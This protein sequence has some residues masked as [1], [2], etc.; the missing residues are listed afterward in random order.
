[1]ENILKYQNPSSPLLIQ[2]INKSGANFVKRLLDPNRKSIPDWETKGSKIATHKLGWAEDDHG[3]YVFPEVQEIDGQLID[4]SRPPYAPGIAD[5]IAHKNNNIVRMSP[6]EADWFTRNYKQYYPSFKKGGSIHI[7]KKNRGKFT[8]SAKRAGMGVQEFARHVLANKDKHSSTLVKRAN[9]ARNSKKFK[10]ENG[11]ILKAQEGTGNLLTPHPLSP[12]GIALN[13]AKAMAK[14]KGEQQYLPPGVKEVVG[15]DGKKV[16]IRTEQPLQPLEQSIAEWLPGTGDVAEV[17]YITNDIKNGNY[18]TA[19]LS[20]GLMILPGNVGKLLGKHRK[21]VSKTADAVE[22]AVRKADVSEYINTIDDALPERQPLTTNKSKQFWDGTSESKL[23]DAEKEGI[24]KGERNNAYKPKVNSKRYFLKSDQLFPMD[25]SE[26]IPDDVVVTNMLKKYQLGNRTWKTR[27]LSFSNMTNR[28]S[29]ELQRA[30]TN[31]IEDFAKSLPDFDPRF[32]R[33]DGV[34]SFYISQFRD[35]LGSMGYNP[36]S[37]SD[38]TLLKI[39]THQYNAL[40]KETT[41]K[42]KGRLF[43]HGTD[44]PFESFDYHMTGK[45]TGNMG[46]NGAGNY[47]STYPTGYGSKY[48]EGYFGKNWKWGLNQPYVITGIKSTPLNDGRIL[49]DKI[50]IPKYISNTD[51]GIKE[52]YDSI[53]Q[54]AISIADSGNTKNMAIIDDYSAYPLAHFDE[55][56]NIPHSEV[57]ISRNDGIKSLFPHPSRFIRNADGTVTLIPT[58]WNDVRVNFKQG[59]K[60]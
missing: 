45:N 6:E 17:G 48:H 52:D 21:A 13:Q 12:V 32:A 19:A 40:A 4:F 51:Y 31:D 5:Y 37:I 60:L 14:M 56:N 22:D 9:F 29:L 44:T 47:F 11:G 39:I 18:G 58:D 28:P 7:K 35:Y 41:G 42:L 23:T 36:S 50:G 16:A 34:P 2:Q 57:S 25:K 46:Y 26:V 20:A 33:E 3:A 27:G 43:F 24:P 49:P 55:G 15:P 8:E 1:M 10:H 59:G 38:E 30:F 54:R 53:I